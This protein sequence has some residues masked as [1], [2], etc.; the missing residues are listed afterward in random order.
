M[1]LKKAPFSET[2]LKK[3]NRWQ[4]SG[5]VHPLT[6]CNIPLR[7]N[8]DYLYCPD[9]GYQQDYIPGVVLTIAEED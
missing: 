4:A 8:A 1:E 7:A 6:C 9:C 2:D 3:F 5:V